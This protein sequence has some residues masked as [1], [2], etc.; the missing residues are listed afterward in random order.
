MKCPTC[1]KGKLYQY[2]ENCIAET[3]AVTTR[4]T[5][6]KRIAMSQD[7]TWGMPDY[8]ECDECKRS[9]DY[10]IDDEGKIYDLDAR[11]EW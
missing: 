2:K 7:K 9:F 4:G 11:Q 6:S 5:I 3:R 10:F 8:L 1:K